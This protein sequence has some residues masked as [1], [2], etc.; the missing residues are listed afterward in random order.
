MRLSLKNLDT[1]CISYIIIYQLFSMSSI[2]PL[3]IVIFNSNSKPSLCQNAFIK[4]NKEPSDF[5]TFSCKSTDIFVCM[6]FSYKSSD[7]F[8]YMMVSYKTSCILVCHKNQTLKCL[9]NSASLFLHV[10]FIF[11]QCH[12]D[13]PENTSRYQLLHFL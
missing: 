12:S 9:I 8:V 2:Q 6:T 5:M 1:F 10:F 7:I 11:S 13:L 3:Y 4:F